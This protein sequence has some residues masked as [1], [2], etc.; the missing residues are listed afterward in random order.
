MQKI[1]CA[2]NNEK[3]NLQSCDWRAEYLIKQI[4]FY[5]PEVLFFERSA[6]TFS[7]EFYNEIRNRFPF[8]KVLCG[9]ISWELTDFSVMKRLK[10]FDFIFVGDDLLCKQLS[11]F[12][13]N[14]N[15]LY[16]SVDYSLK[17]FIKFNLEKK[18]G[19]T[20][21]G[22]SGYGFCDWSGNPDH[23]HRYHDLIR[24][25]EKT[26][27]KI[28]SYEKKISKSEKEFYKKAKIIKHFPSFFLKALEK[29]IP[30]LRKIIKFALELKQKKRIIPWHY[31]KPTLI[32]KY[33]HRVNKSIFGQEYLHILAKS[34]ISFNRHIDN[35][36][37]GGNKRC[38]EATAMGS[39]LLT[40]RKQ[41]LQHL[42]E[43]DKDA[44][45]YSTID[46]AIEKAKY[47]LENEKICSEIAKNGQK[48]T[49]KD[50]TYLERC[51]AMIEKFQKFM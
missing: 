33:P 21:L 46:E 48:R 23:Y 31:Y 2:K 4:K 32:E 43:P 8:I 20:F 39:C 13:I 40:D 14:A 47:L 9:T 51:K 11:S 1:W 36:N 37:H 35:P 17:D 6:L 44:V 22:S 3:E 45:Y 28:W 42:F 41:Q 49:L 27:I 16:H 5:E 24:M 26:P 7:E 15:V 19:L 10:Y 50:H 34:K 25:I 18:H 38:F 29:L 30:G 12:G